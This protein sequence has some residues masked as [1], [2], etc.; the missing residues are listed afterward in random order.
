MEWIR[1]GDIA[2]KITKGTTP[3]SVG[4]DFIECGINF[5]KVESITENRKFISSK[6]A[7]ISE[8]CNEKLNRSQLKENDILFSIAGV[9]GR[10]AIVH[11]DI[12]PANTNQALAI[13]RVPNGRIDYSFLAYALES[14]MV[15]KQYEK[16]QQGVAQINVSL[17]NVG[18]FLIPRLEL[19]EQ[20][21]IAATLNKV[22]DLIA[23]RRAQLDKL[24][25]LV[26]ARFV[27]MFGDITANPK[28]WKK[29]KLQSHIDMIAGFPFNSSGYSENGVK[30]CG[31]LII[32]PDQIKWDECKFW[33]DSLGYEP[34]LL[35]E[36]DIVVAL[37]RPWI[38]EGFKIGE[39]QAEDLP[40]LL[41]QRT[42]RIRGRDITQQFLLYLLKDKAFERH[43]TITGSL[44]PHISNKDI[45]S[46][47]VILP[48]F[49]FQQKFD[50]FCN[51]SKLSKL[52]IQQS[53][54]KLETLKKALMQQYFG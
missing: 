54:D 7:H 28:G 22:S 30:I 15:R 33:P 13:I 37:D 14:P 19:E 12:L 41:I 36:G 23:K 40:A 34:F 49:E 44:V 51:K 50:G 3:T 24:D 11:E 1:L 32:M 47:E 5:V 31:G 39:I 26:K 45:N 8:E 16:Q 25:L 38:S 21:R 27:E 18:D 48:P 42:A 53:L 9:I 17:Q 4:Y 43:C 6:F 35:Q 20:R 46:Y 52:T 10:T 2:S 29:E